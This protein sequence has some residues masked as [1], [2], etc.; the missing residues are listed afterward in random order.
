[1]RLLA[2]YPGYQ[3]DGLLGSEGVHWVEMPLARIQ[4]WGFADAVG[5]AKESLA[6]QEGKRGI[7]KTSQAKTAQPEVFSPRHGKVQYGI[8]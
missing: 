6:I 7:C 5:K 4:G 3:L 2:S 1:M 8:A